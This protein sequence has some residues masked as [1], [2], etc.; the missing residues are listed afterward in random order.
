MAPV[1]QYRRTGASQVTYMCCDP[2]RRQRRPQRAGTGRR[3]D[4]KP[5]PQRRLHR[6]LARIADAGTAR[7]GDE[8]HGLAAAQP[9][10]DSF[11]AFGLVELKIAEQWLR[12]LKT[13][14]Q[15]SGAPRVLGR[16]HVAFLERAQGPQRDIL[17]VADWRRAQI[18]SAAI[19]GRESNPSGDTYRSV[20][21]SKAYN[22]VSR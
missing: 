10:D 3:V 11:A 7:V 4:A 17:Q 2:A 14:Q 19:Y 12:D 6:A 16:H 8:R 1:T 18:E 20:S 22:L 21:F 15:L 9:G 13:F 5:R